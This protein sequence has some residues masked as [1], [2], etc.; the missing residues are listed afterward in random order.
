MIIS[1][2]NIAT[3]PTLDGSVSFAPQ[4]TKSVYGWNPGGL[5]VAACRR[6]PWEMAEFCGKK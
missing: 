4:V 6:W 2:K 1:H 5:R 3:Q